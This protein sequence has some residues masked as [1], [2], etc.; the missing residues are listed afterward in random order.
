MSF[1]SAL[2]GA[3]KIRPQFNVGALVDIPT[4]RYHR[5][6]DGSHILN[7]GIGGTT[8]IV[9]PGNSFKSEILNYFYFTVPA[10]YPETTGSFFDTE[11]SMTFERLHRTAMMTR[12][13]QGFDLAD[14]ENGIFVMTQ[15]A[16][17]LGDA[18]F[19]EMKKMVKA[20]IAMKKKIEKTTPFVTD[21]GNPICIMPP[22][23]AGIDSLS[24]FKVSAVQEKLV[25]K[26]AVGESGANTQF[27]KD[28]A[29]KTQ[30]ITQLPNMSV[31]G[32][33]CFMMVAH[34]GMPIEMDQYAP[35]APSLTH[36]RSGRKTKGV[37]EKFSFI[38]NLLLE[39]QDAK[40]LYNS[41]SDKS[42]MYPLSEADRENGTPDLTIVYLKTTRNKGGASGVTI[43]LIVSQG[44]GLQP[45]LSE[46]HYIKTSDR[47]GLVGNNT[48]YALALYPDCKIGR[49]TVRKKINEDPKLCRAI[50]ITSEMRQM[51]QW[52]RGLNEDLHCSPDVLYED[53]KKLGYDWDELLDTVSHWTWVGDE[54]NFKPRLTTMDLLKMR[55]GE[56]VPAWVK[57][58]PKGK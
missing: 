44:E 4:G 57:N 56:Y 49:T 25:D 18:Y 3:P 40:V 21:K 33:I 26:N 28:G 7:G 20:K 5:M 31:Q 23:M 53:L 34:V 43:D 22:T 37:P 8:S 10:R 29:A 48:T 1:L 45:T 9:G 36:S 47:Y 27:M 52:W 12:A 38:N 58:K 54:D 13:W 15:Q 50:Q 19:E 42:A 6:E 55:V 30:L 51:E 16:D 39:I 17:M 24:E 2:P 11:N 35:K 41:S 14:P 46:F 32:S